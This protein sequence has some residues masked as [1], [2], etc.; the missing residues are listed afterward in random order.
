MQRSRY[1]SQRKTQTERRP[2]KTKRRTTIP[3]LNTYLLSYFCFYRLNIFCTFMIGK[4]LSFTWANFALSFQI[5]KQMKQYFLAKS[6]FF[7]LR[8]IFTREYTKH[9]SGTQ[10]T[11][12]ICLLHSSQTHKPKERK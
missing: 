11:N 5:N 10:Q 1:C 4:T 9:A 7:Q 8:K 2:N 3:L 12:I 6:N